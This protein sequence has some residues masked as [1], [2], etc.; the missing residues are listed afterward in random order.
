MSECS[1]CKSGFCPWDNIIPWVDKDKRPFPLPFPFPFPEDFL[2]N[3][4]KCDQCEQRSRMIVHRPLHND[5]G[6]WCINCKPKYY[7]PK[8][9]HDNYPLITMA[10]PTGWKYM[11]KDEICA[12]WKVL[13][14]QRKANE[15]KVEEEVLKEISRRN[16]SPDDLDELGRIIIIE[17]LAENKRDNHGE[18]RS[19]IFALIE[20]SEQFVKANFPFGLE[21]PPENIGL[22]Q[23][24][25]MSVLGFKSMK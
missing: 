10:Y 14:T 12:F 20:R 11:T 24:A 7:N 13:E 21:I 5:E 17:L 8:N 4:W 23:R 25:C 18:Y 2:D 3:F 22:V 19:N 16:L 1:E 9:F 6:Y 15:P